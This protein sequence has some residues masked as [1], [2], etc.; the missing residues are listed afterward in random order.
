MRWK[1]AIGVTLFVI[2]GLIT[3]AYV[4]LSSYDYNK[5]KPRIAA[6]VRGATGRELKIKGDVE[7]QIGLSPTLIV[8]KASFQNAS[9]GSR[10]EMAKI[11]RLELQVRLLPLIKGRVEIKRLV[12]IKPDVFIETDKSGRSN[13]QFSAGNGKGPAQAK[14]GTEQKGLPTLSFQDVRILGGRFTYRDGKARRTYKFL[15]DSLQAQSEESEGVLYLNLDGTYR[16]SPFSISGILSPVSALLDPSHR[17]SIKA[18]VMIAGTKISINGFVTDLVKAKGFDLKISAI[19]SSLSRLALLA[20]HPIQLD[21]GSFKANMEVGDLAGKPCIGKL[22]ASV[23]LKRLGRLKASGAV[24]DAVG[25]KGIDIKFDLRGN[26][27]SDL[28]RMVK[29]RIPFEG[30][31]KVSGRVNDTGRKKYR[32]SS[33]QVAL[34]D[35]FIYGSLQV[36]ISRKKPRL[37]G[38]LA[39][40]KI[41]LRKVLSGKGHKGEK[42]RALRAKASKGK[43][44]FSDRP[45]SLHALRQFN[46]RLSLKCKKL[47]LPRLVLADF[48][49]NLDLENGQLKVKSFK[50]H[51]GGG[52]VSGSLDLTPAGRKTKVASMVIA[53]HVDVGWVFKELKKEPILEGKL[54]AD[55]EFNGCGNSV[56]S[57]MSGLN[58]KTVVIMGEGR[59]NNNYVELLGADLASGIFRLINPFKDRSDYTQINC[60][61]SGFRIKGGIAKVTAL[62]MD[63]EKMSVIGDGS[64]NLRTEALDLSLKPSPKRGIKTGIFGKLSMSFGQLAKPFKLAGTLGN[65]SLAVDPTQT[66]LTL[67]KAAGG[68]ALFGPLGIAAALA[69]SS[70]SDKNPCLLAIEAAKKGVRLEEE[71]KAQKQK[72]EKGKSSEGLKGVIDSFGN[73][74]QK[75]F[76]D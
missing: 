2:A 32:I 37:S 5:L 55:V 75:L 23:D 41:D 42:T 44:V 45:F 24:Q 14:K 73:A 33:L 7:I 17:S 49:T 27:I 39:S 11:G 35:S 70:P 30:A 26:D 28:G 50:T 64:I 53:R 69:G 71:K 1:I 56:A 13:L 16:R 66:A 40:S 63:S 72:K 76:G 52:R 48:R 57:L 36:D 58:G 54:D 21:L 31:F 18:D 74:I 10:P 9:W 29:T 46:A 15:L 61:V 22:R 19:G 51:V 12:I 67:G 34:A 60:F 65:P 25:L 47:V 6:E 8:N 62:V 68:M 59:I 38:T 43:K 20:G 3:G 4:V